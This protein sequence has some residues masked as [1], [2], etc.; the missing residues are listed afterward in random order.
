M[1]TQF[2]QFIISSSF[3]GVIGC[4][5]TTLP[6][7][8]K[9]SIHD[10]ES[11]IERATTK[12]AKA[13][14]VQS[15]NFIQHTDTGYFGNQTV[16]QN[17]TDFLPPIFSNQI[18][19]DQQFFGLKSIATGLTELTR[20]PTILDNPNNTPTTNSCAA[21]RITQQEG[22]LIDLLNLLG[23]RCDIDWSYREGKIIL[24][25][26]E[27]QTWPIK[28]IPGDIQVYNQ[29]NNNSGV[30]GQ[31]G[32]MGASIGGSSSGGASGLSQASSNQSSTQNIAFNLQNS[33]W[34]NLEDAIK[35]MLSRVGKLSISPATSSL[36]VTDR[37]SVLL[38]VDRYVRNQNN[39]LK[40][41]V[42]IDVQVLNVDVEKSDN[43]GINWNLALQVANTKFTINGQAITQ[44]SSNGG[45]KTTLSPVFV[46]SNTTQAFTIGLPGSAADSNASGLVINALSTITKTALVTSTAITTLSNQPVP[47]QFVDQLAYLASVSTTVTG[48]AGTTQTSLTPGQLTTGFSLN[49]LP[50]IEADG[51]VNLQLSLNIS[52]LKNMAQYASGGS[53]LQLP[54]TLQRNFMQKVVI[55]SG[56]TFVMTGFDSNAQNI[57]NNGVGS[58]DNWL[59]GSGI[60]AEEN[61]T[62]M[63]VLVTP[64]IINL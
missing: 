22:N 41:Q 38:R 13:R 57:R 18:Q 5:L 42:Q 59:F 54:E 4:S 58:A 6:S 2:K 56:D 39:I 19:L 21:V 24:S 40:R 43:Y 36:T 47:V 29:I 1:K 7:D 34:K 32:A 51:K 9:K 30:K 35:S 17:D 53:S 16:V 25:D 12:V 52:A 23:A 50:V 63:V 48:A 27:T 33:L 44:D 49:I 61:R 10:T 26:T 20:I 14:T 45:T 46:P 55:K 37:P 31:A 11:G 64:R 62:R 3:I 60:S 15:N 8:V 28:G